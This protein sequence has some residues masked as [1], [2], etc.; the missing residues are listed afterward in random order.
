MTVDVSFL[1][2]LRELNLVMKRRVSTLYTGGRPSVQYGRGLEPVDHREY[3]GG[4]DFRLIDWRL[5][6]R[7]EKLYIRR[8]EEEKNLVLHILIDASK[9]MDFKGTGMRK[10]DY[11]SSM[12]IGF[13][14][15]ALHNNEKFGLA[16]YADVLKDFMR[17][18]RTKTHLFKSIN[19]LNSVT[20]EGKT[21]FA[22]CASQYIKMMKTKSFIVL[23]SDFMEPIDSLREG[24]YR[25]AKYSKELILIQVLDPDEVD[26]KWADDVK[27]EDLETQEVEISFLSPN[28]KEKYHERVKEHILKVQEICDEVGAD[29]ISIRTNTPV[30]DAFVDLLGGAVRYG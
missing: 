8:F 13:G 25:I 16:L 27:F 5:Y 9:S 20:L 15:L 6:G 4:D 3:V 30:F 17:A 10:F 1:E 28:F 14:Y 12:A 21:D 19:L 22:I 18:D 2:Q 29:F 26:L 11:A 24:I 7:T 23:I